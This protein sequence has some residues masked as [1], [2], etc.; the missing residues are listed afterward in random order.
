MQTSSTSLN[1][2][3]MFPANIT[4]RGEKGQQG[5]SNYLSVATGRSSP[6]WE[7]WT[8]GSE[9]KQRQQLMFL[10]VYVCVHFYCLQHG[11]YTKVNFPIAIINLSY[12][13]MQS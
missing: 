10:H 1:N 9:N 8:F 4:A 11:C 7:V 6:Y 5:N 3:G 12:I 2:T 13:M